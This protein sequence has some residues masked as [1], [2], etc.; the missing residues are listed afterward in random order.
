MT[1]KAPLRWLTWLGAAL[2]ALTIFGLLLDLP[3]ATGDLR[4]LRVSIL[5]GLLAFSAAI[6]FVAARLVLRHSW[7]RGTIWLVLGVA[8]A[9]RVLLLTEPPN[10]RG[11]IKAPPNGSDITQSV[12]PASLGRWCRGF[13]AGMY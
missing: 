1:A 3:A 7:P 9:L 13:V 6:Y 5:L 2:L 11:S 4:S 12:T 8:S 10:G